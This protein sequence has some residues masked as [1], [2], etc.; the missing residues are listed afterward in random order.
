[1]AALHEIL[2]CSNGIEHGSNAYRLSL[3]NVVLGIA[4]TITPHGEE[5]ATH[6]F[7]VVLVSGKSATT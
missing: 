2:L 3:V 1:L 5:G 7:E 4:C 6:R